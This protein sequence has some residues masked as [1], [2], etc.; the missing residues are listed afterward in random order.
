MK[1]EIYEHLIIPLSFYQEG[2]NEFELKRYINA[3][4]NFYFYLEDL[5][6]NGK[7]KNYQIRREFLKS[8]QLKEAVSKTI[9]EFKNG[10]SKKHYKNLKSF[11][12]LE[13]CSYDIEG[14]ISLI[15]KVRG[16]L[17]HFSQKS[18]KKLGH[19]FNQKDFETMA[20]LLMS[21]CVKTYTRLTTGEKPCYV[22][23]IRRL[24]QSLRFHSYRRS[25]QIDSPSQVWLRLINFVNP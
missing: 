22:R 23:C 6:G 18:S 9:E 15:V 17:H 11:L 20:F 1:K 13:S 5:Y 16:N 8:N 10:P 21:I 7:T 24:T 12:K 3:Y 19:P 25:T 14:V 2:R 4:Y